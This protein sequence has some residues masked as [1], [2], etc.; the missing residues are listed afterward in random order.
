MLS[1]MTACY[2]QALVP[3]LTRRT[4]L[5]SASALP[6]L[7]LLGSLTRPPA[8]FAQTAVVT[9]TTLAVEPDSKRGANFAFA[10]DGQNVVAFLGDG[11]GQSITL[12]EWFQGP[13]NRGSIRLTSGDGAQLALDLTPAV[14]TG[15]VHLPDGRE[16]PIVATGVYADSPRTSQG[17]IP[18]FWVDTETLGGARYLA[19]A[20]ALGTGPDTFVHVDLP[21]SVRRGAL[22]NLDTGEIQPLPDPSSGLADGTRVDVAGLGSFTL[23]A[24]APQA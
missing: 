19:V 17:D 7:S 15:S 21:P 8:V 5:L 18:G 6:A 9:F 13:I 1:E 14:A 24:A 11:D 22:I 16:I 4:L 23:H 3:R 20:V 10:T 12:A 2:K